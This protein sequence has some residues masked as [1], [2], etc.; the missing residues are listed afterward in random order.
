M[1][2]LITPERSAYTSPIA[3]ISSGAAHRRVAC[4]QSI[5]MSIVMLVALLCVRSP[6]ILFC[7]VVILT[8]VHN[9]R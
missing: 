6:D 7:V 1:P 2:M 8:V 5:I 3:T 4:S 9:P